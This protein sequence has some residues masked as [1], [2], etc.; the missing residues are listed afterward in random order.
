VWT[1]DVVGGLLP[2]RPI[3]P[4]SEFV[5]CARTVFAEILMYEIAERPEK[6]IRSFVRI[7]EDLRVALAE[8]VHCLSSDKST[9]VERSEAV[10]RN[11]E[12]HAQNNRPIKSRKCIEAVACT[13]KPP[14]VNVRSQ[15]VECAVLPSGSAGNMYAKPQ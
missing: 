14:D 2:D 3:N 8:S 4:I 10:G 5:E 11:P 12:P 15:S 9:Y 1:T 7:Y 6:F 13:R